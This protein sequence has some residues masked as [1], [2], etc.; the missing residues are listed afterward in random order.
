MIKILQFISLLAN[1]GIDIFF[2]IFRSSF[3]FT[4]SQEKIEGRIGV[5]YHSIEKGLSMDCIR[6]KFGKAKITK[7]I[8]WIRFYSTKGNDINRTQFKTACY[9]LAKYYEL[10]NSLGIE[11]GD[12]FNVKDYEYLNN[13]KGK[14]GGTTSITGDSYFNSS[15]GNFKKFSNSRKSIRYFTEKLITEDEIL[16][17]LDIAK[18]SP[19]VCN[20]QPY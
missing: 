5:L 7:L 12:Y 14:C 11:I 4:N 16:S 17:V 20:R 18:N 10:H 8:Y 3:F 13:N 9:V 2:Y 19:S 6:Y 15:N 1:Y